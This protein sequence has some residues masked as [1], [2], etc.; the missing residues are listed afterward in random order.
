MNPGA[1]LRILSAAA[2]GFLLA[3]AGAAQDARTRIKPGINSFTP[4]QYIELGQKLAAETEQKKQLCNNPKLDAYLTKLGKTLL[5]QLNTGG[6]EYPWE[7]HCVN[8]ETLNAYALPGGFV[9]VNR[10]SIEAA[11]NEAELAGI[12]AHEMSHVALRHGTNQLTKAQYAQ[13]G[14]GILGAAGGVFGGATGAAAAGVGHYAS[15]GLLL[16]YSRTAEVQ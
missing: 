6:V 1:H 16:R 8:D 12:L 9:F 14:T 10:G 11:D 7:F 15:G 5:E 13:L 4:Q 3:C 2:F